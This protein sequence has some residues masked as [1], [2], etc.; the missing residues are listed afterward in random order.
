MKTLLFL[1]YIA[2]LLSETLSF[3]VC[4]PSGTLMK[5]DNDE[6]CA[7]VFVCGCKCLLFVCPSESLTG[8]KHSRCRAPP[9]IVDRDQ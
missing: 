8:C 6:L 3:C 2:F 7:G 4:T 9:S 1:G 5:E